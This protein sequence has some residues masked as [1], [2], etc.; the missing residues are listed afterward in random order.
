[1]LAPELARLEALV[2][3]FDRVH[4]LVVGDLVLDGY[5]FG[6]VDRVSPEA[7]VPVVQ[8]VEETEVLGGAA[9]VVRNI[10]AL[11][12]TASF[13]SAV[14]TDEAGR[15]AA[16][17]LSEL[18][19]DPAGLVSVEGRPTTRKTRAPCNSVCRLRCYPLMHAFR[20]RIL[21]LV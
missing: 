6:D 8:V 4:L 19:V 2:D 17:L 12:G 7:P 10:A 11:G 18:G 5:V 1:M 3:S 20:V 14:G 21:R 9:N 15:R 16:D 13:C